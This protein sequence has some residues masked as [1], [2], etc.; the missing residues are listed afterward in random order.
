MTM[1]FNISNPIISL[2]KELFNQAKTMNKKELQEVLFFEEE[3]S[4]KWSL[5]KCRIQYVKDQLNFIR[6]N[7]VS[8]WEYVEDN[9]RLIFIGEN[10]NEG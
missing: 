9:A 6:N 3:T 7:M 10:D 1:S 4:D 2:A 8:E 5:D